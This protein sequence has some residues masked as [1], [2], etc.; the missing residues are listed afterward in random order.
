MNN[1]NRFLAPRRRDAKGDKTFSR[2]EAQEDGR[3]KHPTQNPA[4]SGQ[5]LNIQRNWNSR[6]LRGGP[7]PWQNGPI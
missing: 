4:V 6:K 7:H 3:R 5:A 2:K 1:T